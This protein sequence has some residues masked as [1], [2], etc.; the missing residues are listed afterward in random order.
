MLRRIVILAATLCVAAPLAA[1][2]GR[3]ATLTLG[4]YVC[5]RPGS[6]ATQAPV[7]DAAAS[8]AIT[9]ASRYVAIDGTRGTY[10]LTGD[11]AELT[12]GPLAGT[13]LVRVRDSFLRVIGPDGLPGPTRCILSRNSDKH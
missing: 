10:L 7:T 11:I 12:S 8:F 9:T 6:D 13:R 5:E 2:P 1:G 3:L 4:R